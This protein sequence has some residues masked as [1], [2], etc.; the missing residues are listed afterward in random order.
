MYTG[1]HIGKI[2]YTNHTFLW[3]GVITYKEV[4]KWMAIYIGKIEDKRAFK[5]GKM[6]LYI[7]SADCKVHELEAQDESFGT[8]RA[9][10]SHRW[11]NRHKVVHMRSPYILKLMPNFSWTIY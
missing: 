3:Y 2:S 6:T 11:T 9:L 10:S 7:Y 8:K 5:L 1:Y 4:T